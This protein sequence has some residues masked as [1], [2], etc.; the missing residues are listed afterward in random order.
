MLNVSMSEVLIECQ[1]YRMSKFDLRAADQLLELIFKSVNICR[2]ESL[3]Y[4][5]EMQIECLN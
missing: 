1:D 2:I 5:F 3:I 4:E